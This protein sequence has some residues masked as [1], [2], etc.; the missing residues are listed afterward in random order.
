MEERTWGTKERLD[1][2]QRIIERTPHDQIAVG[3]GFSLI[4][5]PEKCARCIANTA[6]VEI[7][8]FFH[9]IESRTEKEV[10]EFVAAL[11][12]VRE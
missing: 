4:H 10:S 12:G 5:N 3:A 11:E 6:T 7:G 1:S 9:A 2:I 8:R